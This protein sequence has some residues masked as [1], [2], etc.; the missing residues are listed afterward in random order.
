MEN[1]YIFSCNNKLHTKQFTRK[2]SKAEK[3]IIIVIFSISFNEKNL[4]EM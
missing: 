2:H 4:G 3:I 1:E